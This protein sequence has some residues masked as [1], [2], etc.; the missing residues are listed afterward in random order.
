[1]DELLKRIEVLEQALELE[2]SLNAEQQQA[3]AQHIRQNRRSIDTI[4]A[5]LLGFAGFSL[6]IILAG[7][8][9]EW[10]GGSFALPE[11]FLEWAL[12]ASGASMIATQLLDRLKS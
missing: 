5:A 12:G 3:I 7:L 1:M 4:G 6:V 8:R 2:R 11:T 9:L 10:Q